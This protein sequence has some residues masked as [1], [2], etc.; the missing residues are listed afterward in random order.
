MRILS[1]AVMV[2]YVFTVIGFDV[3]MSSESGKAYFEPLYAGISC[4]DIHPDHPCHHC[5]DHCCG[6][7]DCDG[8]EDGCLEDEV[9][10]S[11]NIGVLTLTGTDHQSC[12]FLAPAVTA[13]AVITPAQGL[14]GMA[15]PVHSG[16]F[17]APPRSALSRF[18]ILRV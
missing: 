3:H 11:D 15:F 18:C 9:C 1:F 16:V 17:R 14:S 4:E 8:G 13:L 5:G 12:D 6:V 7:H 10:C 2:M